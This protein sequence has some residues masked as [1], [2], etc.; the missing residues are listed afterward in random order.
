MSV[1]TSW[2]PELAVSPRVWRDGPVLHARTRGR[3]R[4][5]TA[6]AYDRHLIVDPTLRQITLTVRRYW[7]SVSSET[8]DFD[9]VAAL[10]YRYARMPTE[11]GMTL[12][13]GQWTDSV[14]WYVVTLVLRTARDPV[15]LFRFA[16]EGSEGT[17]WSGTI[18]GDDLVDLE[19]TQEVESREFVN[20]L[21]RLLKVPVQ[22][23]ME[24][25][26]SR[27]FAGRVMPCPN[28][29]RSIAITAPR[30]S[31]CGK[32]LRPTKSEP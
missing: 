10:E 20:T 21:R 17:G 32:T 8:H 29:E 19:G 24:R 9:D 2:L 12:Q 6:F 25:M 15:T 27:A 1:L 11:I 13:G 7:V 3:H 18:L 14:N 5:L 28:C 23:R 22:S 26:V 31:Y 30:C 16:G 4:L